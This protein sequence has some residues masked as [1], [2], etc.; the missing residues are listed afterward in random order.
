MVKAGNIIK[1]CNGVMDD[2]N[3]YGWV[4]SSFRPT[5][6]RVDTSTILFLYNFFQI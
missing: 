6:L 2:D 5:C 4:D 3:K 1:M